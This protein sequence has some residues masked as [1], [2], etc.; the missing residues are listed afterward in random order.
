MDITIL[1]AKVLGIYLLVSGLFLI[2][3]GKTIPNLLKDFFG[4]PATVFLTGI[5]LIFLS[6]I[7]LIQY[8]VWNG[9]AQVLVTLFVCLVMLKGLFYVFF[10]QILNEV[11]LK[12]FRGPFVVYGLI[13]IV[14]GLYLFFL[15]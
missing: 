9:T 5:I 2:I 10:P 15:K 12:R 8:S 6:S 13:A 1:V 3:R 4:H 14:I 11:S 7:Y